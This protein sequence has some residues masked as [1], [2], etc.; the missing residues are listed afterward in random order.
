MDARPRPAPPEPDSIPLLTSLLVLFIA[1]TAMYLRTAPPAPRPAD[2]PAS[3]FSATRAREV[4]R[5]LVGDGAPHPVGSDANAEVRARIVQSFA[6]LGYAPQVQTTFACSGTDQ[7][8]AT[9][10][11]IVVERAG[12]DAGP[13]VLVATHYDSVPAGPGAS[14]AGVSV[15]AV[16]EAARAL[17]AEPPAQNPVVFLVSDAEEAGLIGASAFVAEHPL[18]A[19]VGVVVNLEARGTSGPSVMFET[20]AGNAWLIDRLAASLPRPVASSLFYP[21]YERLPNDTDLT[22]FKAAGIPGVNFAFIGGGS[23]YHTPLDRVGNASPSSLQHQGE[24][25]LAIVRAFAEAD[26]SSPPEGSVVFFDVLGARVVSWPVSFTTPLAVLAFLLVAATAVLSWRAGGAPFWRDFVGLAGWVVALGVSALASWLWL[27]QM[28]GLGAWPGGA[29]TRPAL[30]VLAFWVLGLAVALLVAVIV[31]RW[32]RVAGAW[33]GCWLGW[34]AAGVAAAV[35]FPEASYV[36][37][38]PALVAGAAGAAGTAIRRQA[39]GTVAAMLPMATA[40]VL[41]MPSAWMLFEALGPQALPIVGTAIA[42]VG[43]GLAPLAAR[44]GGVRWLV[45][46]AAL[47]TAGTLS[48]LSLRAEAFSPAS[49]ERMNITLFQRAEEP[50]ARWLLSPQSGVLPEALRLAA[51]FG[52]EREVAFPWSAAVAFSAAADPLPWEAPTI[53]VIDQGVR[54]GH[55]FVRLRAVSPRGA[56]VMTLLLPRSRVVSISVDGRDVPQRPEGGVVRPSPRD[57]GPPLGGY[58]HHTVP[59]EGVEIEVVITGDGPLEGYLIDRSYGLPPAGAPI[60]GARPVT[61][62]LAGLGDVIV[63]ARR[64]GF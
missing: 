57:A 54:D 50:R 39:P 52:A 5:V 34:S 59:S 1:F 10:H 21:V 53:E 33:T 35:T 9:V 15:A 61:A 63:L 46:I 3:A 31:A 42:L 55:R 40:A 16:L 27:R 6:D 11:N 28:T 23:Q 8:C 22:V 29:T 51:P 38:V 19:N 2:A 58:T 47:A 30:A 48:A 12:R 62:T 18:A 64:I 7:A 4:L 36:L 49:P 56:P 24:N 26:L 45:P 13:V 17:A 41:I 60:A 32:A 43:T 14:D 20:S 25:T 37:I 44:A